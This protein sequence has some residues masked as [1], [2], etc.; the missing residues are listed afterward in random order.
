MHIS[1]IWPAPQEQARGSVDLRRNNL[2]PSVQFALDAITD[3]PAFVRNARMD[4]LAANRLG[5]ALH[6]EMYVDPVRPANYARFIFLDEE[7]ARRFF[8]DW[9]LAANNMV[10]I[11]RTEAGRDPFDRGLSDLV[12]ELSTRS[13]E[14]RTRWAAHNVR[15]HYSGFKHFHHPVVGELRLLFEA[16]ELSADTGLSLFIYPAEP[17]SPSADALRLLASWAATQELAEQPQT[18]PASGGV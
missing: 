1:S 3:A 13:D 12:G 18:A 15:R 10:A 9:E 8:P 17:G 2:R 5:R 6:S 16:M 7:R 14:F 4:I 11:L